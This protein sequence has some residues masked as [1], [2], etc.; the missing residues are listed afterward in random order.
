[1]LYSRF[2]NQ[3]FLKIVL[4]FRKAQIQT[5]SGAP[6]PERTVQTKRKDM[7]VGI[8]KNKQKK[9][10]FDALVIGDQQIHIKNKIYGKPTF[11]SKEKSERNLLPIPHTPL[12]DPDHY[13]KTAG[14]PT[15]NNVLPDFLID[16]H[17]LQ[18]ATIHQCKKLYFEA[19]NSP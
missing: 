12:T 15:S 11:L 14:Q 3:S 19:Y 13:S 1:M 7:I 9:Y 6:K 16:C 8:Q 5:N 18:S 2:Q 17:G 4:T 10:I